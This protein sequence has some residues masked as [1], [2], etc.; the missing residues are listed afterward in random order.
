VPNLLASLGCG[1]SGVVYLL[2]DQF[3]TAANAPLATPRTCEPGPGTLTISDAGN[4]ISIANAVLVINGTTTNLNGVASA[5]NA[6]ATGRALLMRLP[7]RTSIVGGVVHFGWGPNAFTNNTMDIGLDVSATTTFRIKSGVSVVDT[8]TLGS[9]IWDFA[10]VMRGTGGF[11]FAR[12]GGS[13]AYTLYWVYNTIA[14]AEFAKIFFSGTQAENLTVDDVRITDLAAPYT[15]DYGIATQRI[16]SNIANDTI[17]ANADAVVEWTW[18]TPAAAG[19][20]DLLVRRT[21]DSNCWII[22]GDQAGATIKLIEKNAGVETERSSVAQTWTALTAFRV[23]VTCD[24]QTIKTYVGV[25]PKNSYTS[26]SFNQTVGGC[27][28]TQAG[29]DF[30]SWP[31]T[32]VFPV[33]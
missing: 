18:T 17:A 1:Q 11:L 25:T 20:F 2:F 5:S 16:A 30:V 21:D 8:I 14:T 13:G 15:T 19:A 24:T 12:N 28:V 10:F 7:T 31:R 6:R 4:I 3:R 22:R 26:A 27:K 33:V 32:L 9:G 23:I 29:A